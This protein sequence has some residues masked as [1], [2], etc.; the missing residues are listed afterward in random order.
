MAWSGMVLFVAQAKAEAQD[1]G[2]V[3]NVCLLELQTAK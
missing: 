3:I 2:L 1:V